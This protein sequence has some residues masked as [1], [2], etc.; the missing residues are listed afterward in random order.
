MKVSNFTENGWGNTIESLSEIENYQE[1]I[2]LIK[3][4][5]KMGIDTDY[6][7][8]RPQKVA[9]KNFYDK[10]V[11]KMLGNNADSIIKHI[12]GMVELHQCHKNS[13]LAGVCINANSKCK[14][15]YCSGTFGYADNI[16]A[17]FFSHSILYIERKGKGVF[18]DPTQFLI[19]RKD[20]D[21]FNLYYIA[22]FEHTL[23][24]LFMKYGQAFSPLFGYDMDLP[25]IS[26]VA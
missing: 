6:F 3:N 26:R 25:E 17:E 14:V 21:T 23:N 18:V 5:G 7:L 10:E 12:K 16:V 4:S 2:L 15:Y 24:D 19:G 11:R 20:K 22:P 8:K 13:A 1:D 9:V